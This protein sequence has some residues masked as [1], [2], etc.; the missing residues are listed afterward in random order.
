MLIHGQ[1]TV[2]QKQDL[3][4]MTE[5]LPEGSMYT[6]YFSLSILTCCREILVRENIPFYNADTSSMF[7]Y[8]MQD[9]KV[10]TSDTRF[11]Q[12]PGDLSSVNSS[13]KR[14]LIACILPLIWSKSCC[15]YRRMFSFCKTIE[16]I[17]APYDGAVVISDLCNLLNCVVTLAFAWLERVIR[18]STPTCS[19]YRSKFFENDCTTENSMSLRFSNVLIG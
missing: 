18:W 6:W 15:H 5:I 17:L 10:H 2:S 9:R 12:K 11:S 13:Y 4:P 1:Q 14:S 3:H 8:K 16:T 7:L 19:P